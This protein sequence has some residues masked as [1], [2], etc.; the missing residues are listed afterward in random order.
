M[1]MDTTKK[2]VEAVQAAV[3]EVERLAG[4]VA[5]WREAPAKLRRERA[6]ELSLL[7]LEHEEEALDPSAP[8]ANQKLAARGLRMVRMEALLKLL[9]ADSRLDFALRG[10]CPDG[11]ALYAAVEILQRLLWEVAEP[12][13]VSHAALIRC[14]LIML[15]SDR[16]PSR[17]AQRLLSYSRNF[18]YGATI[19]VRLAREILSRKVPPLPADFGRSDRDLTPAELQFLEGRSA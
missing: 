2:Q 6:A 19:V 16:Q 12:A 14:G 8:D 15:W 4:A 7:R 1:K 11:A 3:G 9:A 17:G 10:K 5:A 18:F 13:E